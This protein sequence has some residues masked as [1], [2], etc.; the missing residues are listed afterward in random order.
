MGWFKDMICRLM[1]IVPAK[2]K[3]IIIKEPLS[4]QGNVLKNKIWYRGE[5][6]ELEQFFKAASQLDIDYAKFWASVPFRRVRKIHSG[7]VSVVVDRFKD[8]V[9][10]DLDSIDFGEAGKAEPIR[11]RWEE[12][13]KDNDFERI[14]GN[15]VAGALSSGDGAFKISVDTISEYPII[16]FYEADNVDFKYK[17]GRLMEVLFYTKYEKGNKEYQLEET[18]GKGYVKYRL[19]DETGAEVPLTTLEETKDFSDDGFDDDSIMAVPLIIFESCKWKGRG[20][21]LFDAKTDVLD[22]LDEVISQW[23]DAV[24]KGRI[25]RYIPDDMIPRDPETGEIIQPNDFDNDYIAVGTLKG[26]GAADKI[27]ISQP[28]I[29]YE[30]Y[31]NSYANFLDMVLQ[32]IMSPSTLGIDLKKTDNAQSQ[33]EKEKI[34]IHTRNKITDSLNKAIP[35]LVT[36]AMKMHDLMQGKSAGEYD[37]TVKFGEYASPD[38]DSTV[39]TV[40]K[41]KN[42]GVMST[43]KAV[44]EMYGD[45]MTEEEKAEE[46]RRIKEEQGI[47]QMEEPGIN[48]EGLEIKDI[49]AEGR[50]KQNEGKSGKESVQDEPEGVPGSAENSK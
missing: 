2:D 22:A 32:G 41:A 46:V 36:A 37:V 24:R 40:G 6:S 17:R 14:V 25:N 18:Y 42:F 16:E 26:E 31:V 5:P 47:Q 9:V 44:D 7:I 50:E 10:S 29:S 21:A 19:M 38:F 23:L 11:E 1:K 30:A 49:E 34:T 33:R 15:A 39:D 48:T 20:K 28:V 13:A 3:K 27:D 43:E 8:I 4:F 45:T 12:I 35:K